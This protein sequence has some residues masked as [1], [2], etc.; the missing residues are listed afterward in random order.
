MVFLLVLAFSGAV[1]GQG[2]SGTWSGTVDLLPSLGLAS[3]ALELSGTVAGWR[4]GGKGEWFGADGWV[5]QSLDVAGMLASATVEWT[6][7]FGPLAPAFLYSLGK[8]TF[9]IASAD[10]TFYSAMVGPTIPGYFFSGGP[11]GGMVIAAERDLDGFTVGAVVGIGARLQDFVISCLGTYKKTFPVDPFPG[12]FQFTYAELTAEGV[13]FCGGV[14]LDLGLAFTKEA[15]FHH[16]EVVARGLPICCGISFDASARFTTVGKTVAVEPKWEGVGEACLQV[17][18]NA[19]FT[20]HTWRGLEIYGFK[21]RCEL[22]GCSYAEFLTAFNVAKVEE[23]LDEDVFE[24]GEFEY[25]K[26]GFCGPGCC[27]GRYSLDL[28]LYFKPTGT[29]FGLSRFVAEAGGAIMHNLTVTAS[30]TAE[31]G[32]DMGLSVGW[33]FTY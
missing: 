11:A 19:V 33:V 10:F 24:D 32:G 30:F 6:M 7:L 16:L 25:L 13:P 20:D 14:T 31:V 22:G 29:L 8:V 2:V 1:V 23:I 4:V 26:L 28:G 3:T 18:G 27:G 12:G 5:W 15:G 9:P 17:Y 21:A